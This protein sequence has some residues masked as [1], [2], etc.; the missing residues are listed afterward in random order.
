MKKQPADSIRGLKTLERVTDLM[1]NAFRVPGTSF[2]FGLDALLGLVPGAGDTV[3][4]AI[5]GGLLLAM[6][7]GGVSAPILAQMLGNVLLDYLVGLVP[8]LGDFFD[9]TFKANA[10]NLRLLKKY[11]AANPDRRPPSVL[12]SGLQVLAVVGVM[13]LLVVGLLAAGLFALA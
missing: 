13:V 12:K 9:A 8:L 3:G 5:S 1:D 6:I 10:R 7:R 2:R 11:Y 4:L